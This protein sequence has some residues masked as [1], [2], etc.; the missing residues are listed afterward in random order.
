MFF[1][2]KVFES[3]LLELLSI[4]MFP[5]RFHILYLFLYLTN[6]GKKT[7]PKKRLRCDAYKNIFFFTHFMAFRV[8]EDLNHMIHFDRIQHKITIF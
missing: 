7:T 4:L 3:H 8:L 1:L 2:L 5:I 6:D